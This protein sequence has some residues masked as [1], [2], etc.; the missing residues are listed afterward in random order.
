M[1]ETVTSKDNEYAPKDYVI[2]KIEKQT[3]DTNIYTLNCDLNPDPGQFVEV[4]VPYL[5]EAPISVASNDPNKLELLIRNVGSVT[6]AIFK[7][8]EGD[9]LGIRGPYGHGYPM[10]KM[11]G[12]DIIVAGGGTGVAPPM[13]VLKYIEKNQDKY[14][15]VHI[16]LGFRSPQDV[17]F[18][19]DIDRFEKSFSVNL[20]VDRADDTWT[21]DV[22]LITELMEKHDMD[23]KN[24]VVICCGPPIM[25]RC[26]IDQFK[27]RGFSDDQIY[28]SHER[29]MRCGIGKCGHCMIHGKYVCKDGPVFRYDEVNDVSE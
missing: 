11:E 4:S 12:K 7:L 22:G 18:K 17:L 25:I 23:P 15:K 6:N 19:K 3:E 29:H 20:T 26:S 21:C 9:K 10:D 13:G 5:G 28:V 14:G 2:D 8:K 1:S 24:K 27:S 16:F